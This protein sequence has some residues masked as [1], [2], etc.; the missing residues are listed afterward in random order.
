MIYL[1]RS[2][3]VFKQ[4]IP[5]PCHNQYSSLKFLIERITR[6]KIYACP[7]WKEHCFGLD[8]EGVSET[9]QN[10]SDLCL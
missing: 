1:V 5:N 8:A 3:Q 6:N 10:L 9:D 7:Y 2:D 4:T